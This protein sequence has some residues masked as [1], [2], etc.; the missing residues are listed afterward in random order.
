MPLITANSIIDRGETD[1]AFYWRRGRFNG[2]SPTR[3]LKAWEKGK[4]KKYQLRAETAQEMRI[5]K[6]IVDRRW[7]K[8][9][10][11]TEVRSREGGGS[12]W[13]TIGS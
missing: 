2:L 4:G 8:K 9:G 10:G 13:R 3:R 11:G 7:G 5:S 12:H 6:R 1:P